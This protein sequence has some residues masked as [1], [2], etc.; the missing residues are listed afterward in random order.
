MARSEIVLRMSSLRMMTRLCLSFSRP[1]KHKLKINLR[2]PEAEQT[3]HIFM[4]CSPNQVKYL[5][6]FPFSWS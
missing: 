1:R 4:Y 5:Q 3:Y 2:S 6:N